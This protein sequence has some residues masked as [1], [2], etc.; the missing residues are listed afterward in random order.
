MKIFHYSLILFFCFAICTLDVT[1]VEEPD[2]ATFLK[3]Q[4]AIHLYNQSR[5]PLLNGDYETAVTL[6]KEACESFDNNSM[7]QCNY[8]IALL[9]LGKT[10]E[11]LEHLLKAA[12]FKDTINATWMNL[13]LAY[14]AKGQHT[15]AVNALEKYVSLEPT[16]PDIQKIKAYIDLL[17]QQKTL[18]PVGRE[19]AKDD[20]YFADTTKP[21]KLLWGSKNM[22]IKVYM[23]PGIGVAGFKPEYKTLLKEAFDDWTSASTGKITIMFVETKSD[24][25]INSRWISDLSQARNPAEGG[26]VNFHGDANGFKHVE[27][28]LLTVNPSRDMKLTPNLVSWFTHHEVGHALGLLGHSPNGDDIM[29]FSAPQFDRKPTLSTR[30]AKTINM[31]YSCDIGLNEISL[32]NAGLEAS[33][34]GNYEMA[35]EKYTAALAINPAAKTPR[36]NIICAEFNW[37]IKMCRE[38]KYSE[39]EYHFQKALDLEDKNPDENLSVVV[40]NYVSFLRM[41]HRETDAQKVSAKYRN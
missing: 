26:D 34:S 3:Q 4:K 27:I 21:A 31:L 39:A 17:K 40:K 15:E 36:K 7:I 18:S 9:K 10:D 13:G 28:T 20:D 32:N 29:Y 14:E 16:S 24:S 33:N 37:A 12:S 30:D 2:S 41:I 6:L 22:P 5:E 38:G 19:S 8:G 25:D 11:A 35:I 1:A 23:E